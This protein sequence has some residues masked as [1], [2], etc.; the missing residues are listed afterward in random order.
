MTN[1]LV[2]DLKSDL[3][4]CCEKTPKRVVPWSLISKCFGATLVTILICIWFNPLSGGESAHAVS[5]DLVIS[6]D[7]SQ[8]SYGS[9]TLFARAGQTLTFTSTADV[10]HGYLGI[11]V[12][13][14]D[15]IPANNPQPPLQ[16]LS[17]HRNTEAQQND[18]KIDR[19][20][21]YRIE[22][23]PWRDRNRYDITYDVS[24]RVH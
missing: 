11:A 17:I 1:S 9:R 18:I 8:F 10:K 23:T 15:F 4:S 22:I 24:W 21:F 2:D 20:G 3:A 13:R 12:W 16:S 14:H 19:T 7:G 6:L 5:D